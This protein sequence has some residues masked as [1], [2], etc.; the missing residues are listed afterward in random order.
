VHRSRP[1]R[2]RRPSAREARR[3]RQAEGRN[4]VRVFCVRMFMSFMSI[5]R[6][7]MIIISRKSINNGVLQNMMILIINN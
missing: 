1:P 3:P 6:L 4:G 5:T 7:P 2:P